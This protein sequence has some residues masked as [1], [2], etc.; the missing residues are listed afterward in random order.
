MG[1]FLPTRVTYT[2]NGKD[3][4]A[5]NRKTNF[6]QNGKL[7]QSERTLTST[8]KMKRESKADWVDGWVGV[9]GRPPGRWISNLWDGLDNCKQTK[10]P[11]HR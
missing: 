2:K 9:I 8:Q 10:D 11:I 4:L 3:L 6:E 7:F 5:N 1:V